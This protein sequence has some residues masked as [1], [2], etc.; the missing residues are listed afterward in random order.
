[1]KYMRMIALMAVPVAVGGLLLGAGHA[2]STEA[3]TPA[4]TNALLKGGFGMTGLGSLAGSDFGAIQTLVF[5][6]AGKVTGHG[7]VSLIKPALAFP[8][9]LQDGT[10]SVKQDCTGTM[11]WFGHHP[12]VGIADHSHTADIVVS[13]GGKQLSLLYTSTT[14]PN[15]PPGPF[16]SLTMWG[17]HM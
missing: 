1:M 10:Y 8:Y 5:D 13:D 11:R 3:G 2:G 6:G 14:F 12:T 9:D 15:S 7:T 4:C 16:E 17:H